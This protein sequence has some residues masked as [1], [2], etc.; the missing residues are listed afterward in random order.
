MSGA[1]SAIRMARRVAGFI[2][3]AAALAS[4]GMARAADV[5]DHST[6]FVDTADLVVNQA[7]SS[8]I[9]WQ[10][11]Q[12]KALVI[13]EDKLGPNNSWPYERASIFYN[14]AVNIQKFATSFTFRQT[15]ST[16]YPLADGMTFCIQNAG[17]H[18]LGGPG[19]GLGYGPD[20]TPGVGPSISRSVAVKFD[21]WRNGLDPSQNCKGLYTNGA[22]P[23]GGLNLVPLGINLHSGDVFRVDI[24]YTYPTLTVTIT[25]TL[26][27]THVTQYY[28]IDIPAVVGAPTAYVGFTGGTGAYVA[29]QTVL[30]WGYNSI[31][32]APAVAKV[33]V[34]PG[35]VCGGLQATGTVSL[36]EAMPMATV[37]NLSS[38]NP[39][40]SVPA[41]VTV[42]AG[43]LTATFAVA[44]QVVSAAT[45]NSVSAKLGTATTKTTVT[46]N[47]VGIDTASVSLNYLPEGQQSVGTIKLQ[48]AAAPGPITIGLTSAVPG[49]ASVPATV[50]VPAGAT[51]VDFP[52]LTNGVTVN[53]PSL[54]TA[55]ANGSVRTTTLTVRPL[56]VNTVTAPQATLVAGAGETA[57]ITLEAPAPATGVTL[58]LA[59]N[60]SG[61][62]VP[63][64]LFVPAGATTATFPVTTSAVI[65]NTQF[66]VTVSSKV[67]NVY[68][69]IVVT[70]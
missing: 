34:D 47:P 68:A 11:I 43:S 22:I 14:K 19:G 31:P 57:T 60:G 10:P 2:S 50:T 41:S 29:Y 64:T 69:K 28:T 32:L 26:T 59:S 58:A 35:P 49:V 20:P 16:P 23:V 66:T 8:M 15:T 24:S 25:D 18:A 48:A 37:I 36:V 52:I 63:A 17:P 51:S 40:A 12:N 6:G 38:Q 39:A 9:P 27:G 53:T 1:G 46:V 44:T 5:I 30:A 65:A 33:A 62:Q 7:S 61:L 45:T 56:R 4:A 54:I 42:P 21:V 55:R 3:V 67:N 13:T 70:P